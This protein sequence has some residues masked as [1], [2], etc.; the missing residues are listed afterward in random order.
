MRWAW[1]R[2]GRAAEAR[3]IW[4]VGIL[5]GALAGD[6]ANNA[7][8]Q[9]FNLPTIRPPADIPDQIRPCRISRRPAESAPPRRRR[10]AGAAVAAAGRQIRHS[11]RGSSGRAARAGAAP[12]RRPLRLQPAADHQ[13]PALAHLSGEAGPGRLPS[14]QGG[15]GRRAGV[16]AAAGQLRGPCRL[17]PR[18]RDTD[19]PAARRR[20][21]RDLR[22]PRRRPAHH[23]PGR[24]RAHPVRARSGSISSPAASSSPA[25][26]APSCSRS[27][28]AT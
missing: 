18:Q 4:A 10:A 20:R 7:H 15:Q 21:A 17:R 8:A 3:L 28:P 16:L 19:R 22:D 25:T 27:R 2:P 6:A 12:A 13:R 1:E 9:I 24:R 14:A 11:Q 26:A 23:R 5:L